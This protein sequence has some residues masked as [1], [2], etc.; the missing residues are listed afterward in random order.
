MGGIR[1]HAT[2]GVYEYMDA[3]ALCD[4]DTHVLSIVH[5]GQAIAEFPHE[6]YRGYEAIEEQVP[7]VE[8]HHQRRG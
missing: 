3:T 1:V 7:V 5:A 4:P 8:R 6:R 2:E